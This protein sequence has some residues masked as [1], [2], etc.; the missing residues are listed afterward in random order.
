MH[1]ATGRL[2]L[3]ITRA[4]MLWLRVRRTVHAL[5]R[6]SPLWAAAAFTFCC[7]CVR[8]IAQWRVGA[9]M[10]LGFAVVIGCALSILLL[11][12]SHM[13]AMQRVV[14]QT[15]GIQWQRMLRV[16]EI[17]S[18][19]RAIIAA[20]LERMLSP[21]PERI[22]ALES[23]IVADQAVIDS[24]IGE[25][26]D[27]YFRTAGKGILGKI[28]KERADLLQAL[29]RTNELLATGDHAAALALTVRQVA[30]ASKRL[31]RSIQELLVY[32]RGQVETSATAVRA[33]S[34]RARVLLVLLGLAAL[35]SGSLF[36][37]WISRG[38]VQPL[39]CA[40][41]VVERV[42]EGDLTY[43]VTARGRDESAQL[44]AA[45]AHMNADLGTMVLQVREHASSVAQAS[46]AIVRSGDAL[47]QSASEQAERLQAVM[48]RVEQ[49][50]AAVQ[51][52]AANAES[53][54]RLASQAADLAFRSGE[55]VS[56]AVH[57]MADIERAAAKVAEIVGVIDDIAFQTNLLSLNA[58]IE[59]AQAGEHGRGFAVVAG[60]VRSL[61]QRTKEASREVRALIE[62]S[63][64]SVREGRA[65]VDQATATTQEV[66]ATIREVALAVEA[67]HRGAR[68]QAHDVGAVG[69]EAKAL[70]R[71]TERTAALA[72]ASSRSER[73][74]R[75]DAEGLAAAVARFRLPESPGSETV[76]QGC[77]DSQSV[78]P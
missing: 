10:A 11:S 7:N 65:R 45:L 75:A 47:N 23:A 16:T 43:Q 32:Q 54:D 14:E 39:T 69:D 71:L 12:F 9:R 5:W 68:G 4:Q 25:L 73:L 24:T 3:L 46:A 59:A 22:A 57:S 66:I 72:T 21:D 40:L 2:E 19:A 61:S 17:E 62:G 37:W 42:A 48:Q 53:A 63:L 74:L 18:R 15:T 64:A 50:A 28:K 60:E 52:S 44:L 6:R 29:A 70:A 51:T 13:A 38:V 76:V 55:E 27:M 8:A 34:L 36:A 67:I 26:E 31:M 33:A 1:R 78:S 56:A 30:P 58:A 41:A 77:V 35:L 49:L 20:S